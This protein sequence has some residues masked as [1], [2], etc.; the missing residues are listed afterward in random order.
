MPKPDLQR[1]PAHYHNYINL[2]PHNNL[3]EAFIIHQVELYNFLKGLPDEKW[4]YRY[5]EG[6]WSIKEMVQHIIDTERI[7]AYRALCIA[8][9][10]EAPLP[11][12][13]ENSY[14]AASKADKREK[15]HLL[16][17]LKA[18]QTST[19][20]LFQSFDDEQLSTTGNANGKPIDVDAIGFI[21]V[22]HVLHHKKIIQERYL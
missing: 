19:T 18:V 11:G 6:K 20:L 8:R 12:F 22:G 4:S 17:E 16:E 5:A 9:G 13:D 21:A 7:F 3:K 14:A 1:V 2:V 15:E 10:E